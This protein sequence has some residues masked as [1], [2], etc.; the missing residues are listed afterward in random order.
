MDFNHEKMDLEK[1]VD[2]IYDQIKKNRKLKEK[3]MNIEYQSS[4][5]FGNFFYPCLKENIHT[6]KVQFNKDLKIYSYIRTQIFINDLNKDLKNTFAVLEKKYLPQIRTKVITEFIFPIPVHVSPILCLLIQHDQN[7][8]ENSFN[9]IETLYLISKYII[10]Y[11]Q[12]CMNEIDNTIKRL[13]NI[14]K[15]EMLQNLLFHQSKANKNPES[16]KNLKEKHDEIKE[17]IKELDDKLSSLNCTADIKEYQNTFD[18][19]EKIFKD[20]FNNLSVEYDP[21][22]FEEQSNVPQDK[23]DDMFQYLMDPNSDGINKMKIYDDD[24]DDDDD[25]IKLNKKKK[26]L[27][28]SE[29]PGCY[30]KPSI[31]ID[32]DIKLEITKKFVEWNKDFTLIY[33]NLLEILIIKLLKM[34]NDEIGIYNWPNI[35]KNFKSVD[36]KTSIYLLTGDTGV[37]TIDNFIKYEC[38]REYEY[39]YEHEQQVENKFKKEDLLIYHLLETNIIYFK[40]KIDSEKDYIHRNAVLPKVFTHEKITNILN[41]MWDYIFDDETSCMMQ[42]LSS[43]KKKN[44]K[45]DHEINKLLNV[46]KDNGAFFGYIDYS[47]LFLLF[48]INTIFG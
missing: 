45:F 20:K 2:E 48:K 9:I 30:P 46:L 37:F 3:K 42:I 1:C 36:A 47:S 5:W 29:N 27:F 28:K 8:I 34:E 17:K 33:I 43:L 18:K 10:D 22:F 23:W 15:Q 38:E 14:L 31:K 19:F 40:T 25:D 44:T 13:Q 26:K 41:D 12:N 16:H 24:D 32:K 7:K 11:K 6:L 4:S 21:I 39:E 35:K